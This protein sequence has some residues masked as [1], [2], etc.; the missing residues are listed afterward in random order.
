MLKRETQG[1]FLKSAQ[2]EKT[3]KLS[4]NAQRDNKKT[5]REEKKRSKEKHN[6]QRNFLKNAQREKKTRNLF[7]KCSKRK[8]RNLFEKRSKEKQRG[9]F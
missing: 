9:T 6:S 2:R 7:E 5:F 1:N 8:T 4:A 3:R